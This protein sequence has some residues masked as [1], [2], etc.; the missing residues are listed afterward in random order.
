MIRILEK[1]VADKIAAGEVVERPSSIVKELLENS[2]DA[3]SSKI[4]IEIKDGGKS[5]IRV[6]DNG[7]GIEKAEVSL[8][9]FRHATSKIVSERDLESISSL[10]FR[11]EALAS[12]SAVSKVE[13]I[14]KSKNETSAS[15]TVL[16]GGEILEHASFG[17]PQG[18]SIIIRDVFYNTPARL[19]FLKSQKSEASAIIELVSNVAIAYPNIRFML[20][21]NDKIL[22]STNGKGRLIDVISTLTSSVDASKLLSIDYKEDGVYVYGLTSIPSFTKASKKSQ[23]FFVNGRVVNSK[24]IEKG[25]YKAYRDRVFEGRHPI[26]YIFVEVEPEKLDVNI[27]PNKKEVKFDEEN[28][29]SVAVEN[30]I[31]SALNSQVAISTFEDSSFSSSDKIALKVSEDDSFNHSENN[32]FRREK[33]INLETS[34]T[35]YNNENIEDNTLSKEG[36]SQTEYNFDYDI[37]K[38]YELN[39]KEKREKEE[40]TLEVQA[41]IFSE[42][43]AR[44]KKIFDFSKLN[45]LGQVFGTYIQLV[46]EENIYLVDQHAAHERVFFEKFLKDYED[47]TIDR[48]VIFSPY[49]VTISNVQKEFESIWKDIIN[50]CGYTLEEFGL[51]EYR[52]VE[53]PMVFNIGESEKFLADFFDT[54]EESGSLIDKNISEKIA[55]KACKAAIKG[56]MKMSNKEIEILLNQMEACKNPYSCPHGRPTFV[57]IEKKEIEKKFKRI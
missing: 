26:S 30:A 40:L 24:V 13:I 43:E 57:K 28:F 36:K 6:S 42:N 20:I 10:G 1:K 22:F 4:T 31:V 19:K 55:T 32:F 29:I 23:I 53:I 5:Y 8:A 17:A 44:S 48:Q 47:A 7:I 37:L 15:R 56:N 45:I 9:F 39:E 16:W 46:D 41:E 33:N 52:V 34:Y 49:V 35:K 18:T 12:I 14:T 21:N 25:L 38:D 50:R 11:G 51:R 3:K 54:F 2:I 27:H